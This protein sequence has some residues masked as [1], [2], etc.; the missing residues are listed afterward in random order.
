MTFIKPKLLCCMTSFL[1]SLQL[2]ATAWG[3]LNTPLN[4]LWYSEAAGDWE[5]LGLPIGNGAM[6]AVITGHVQQERIQFNEKTLWEGGPGSKAG[7]TFGR[8]AGDF[9][10]ALT[11]IQQRISE[12]G[13]VSPEAAAAA[14]GQASPGYGNYQTFGDIVVNW[15]HKGDISH[16]RRELD[17]NTG[18]AS[19]RYQVEGIHFRREYFASYPDGV[20][21]IRFSASKPGALN[22]NIGLDLPSNR[23]VVF[24]TQS[25]HA[26]SDSSQQA[27]IGVEGQLNDNGLSYASQLQLRSHGGQLVSSGSTDAPQIRVVGADT[28]TLLLSA[29]TNYE[30]QYPHYR[31]TSAP[32]ADVSQ[33]LS[34]AQKMGYNI[35]KQRHIDDH[36]GL[37]SRV[38]LQLGHAGPSAQVNAA[39]L[40]T[41]ALLANYGKGNTA[42]D[43]QLESLFFQYGRYLLI[44]SSRAGSLPANLQGVWNHSNTPPWNADYHVN[45]NLQMNYWPAH[46]TNL[47]ETSAPLYDFIDALI[48]SGRDSLKSMGID[49]GWTLFLNTN[50]YGYTGLIAWPTAFWQPEGG[51]WLARLYYDHYLFTL[52]E[53]FLRHRAY[54]AMKSAAQF[55]LAFLSE[56]ENNTLL[57]NPSYSPEHGLFTAGAAMSQQIVSQLFRDTLTTANRVDD[58]AFAEQLNEALERLE[59]GLRIGQWGQLQEW[60]ADIDESYNQHRHISHLYALHP[61]TAVSPLTTPELAAAAR[62]SLNGRGDAGTGWSKAW[63]I[64]MWARLHQGDRALKLLSE[65]L[66]HSTLKNLW[67]NHP[68]FQI[69]GNFGA[70]A[71][72]AEMLLQSH[73]GELHLLPALPTA[74]PKGEVRGLKARGNIEVDIRW[75]QGQL[76]QAVLKTQHNGAVSVRSGFPCHRIILQSHGKHLKHSCHLG[77]LVFPASSNS[78]YQLTIAA[79][80]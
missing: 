71:G 69:D 47:A 45:I 53:Q 31:S 30:D 16:Y 35:L 24:S 21:A 38:I 11:A 75:A 68:P 28:L 7:Y 73:L 33:T 44:A 67:D 10:K 6:G 20:I 58:K 12:Q 60:R 2:A 39:E 78:Q 61:G 13:S 1:L 27:A 66:Q 17:L 26:S 48:P 14:L 80:N 54:P 9:P 19:V 49:H 77:S 72:I 76:E 40:S 42:L 37:F 32:A 70:T 4:T 57:V 3:A 65:Q 51:A 46:T 79:K 56:E 23:S 25:P 50:I 64:N 55:W 8:P 36:Q 15:Q 62:R 74:W 43:R 63:K 18:T 29:A 59:P 52:D 41:D 5:S 34:I 22:L